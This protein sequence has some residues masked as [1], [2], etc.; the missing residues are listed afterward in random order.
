MGSSSESSL[1]LYTGSSCCVLGHS[2]LFHTRPGCSKVH[3]ARL[4]MKFNITFVTFMR[5]FFCLPC[6]HSVLTYTNVNNLLHSREINRLI[7]FSLNHVLGISSPVYGNRFQS[8]IL[9]P[10]LTPP[11][12][13]CPCKFLL[14]PQIRVTLFH[15]G[16]D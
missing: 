12:T 10:I 4:S 8:Q 1:N 9:L 15:P 11:M 13:F 16:I 2:A 14:L 3:K 6:C 7:R 5:D